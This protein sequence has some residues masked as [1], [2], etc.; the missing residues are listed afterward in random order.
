MPDKPVP[1]P[2]AAIARGNRL[3]RT[4]AKLQGGGTVLIIDNTDTGQRC[5]Q[6][7]RPRHLIGKWDSTF[8]RLQISGTGTIPPKA[9]PALINWRRQFIGKIAGQ[10]C[11]HAVAD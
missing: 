2:Q 5:C 10:C 8:G 9:V 1:P 11:L 7:G 4:Q 6:C 3:T